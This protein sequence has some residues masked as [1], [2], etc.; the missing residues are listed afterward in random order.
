ML[1]VVKSA[2][3]TDEEENDLYIPDFLLFE[4]VRDR[5]ARFTGKVSGKVEGF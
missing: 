4:S 3:E 5:Q 1:A 2:I